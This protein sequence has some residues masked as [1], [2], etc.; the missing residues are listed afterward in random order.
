MFSSPA[1]STDGK[2]NN[3]KFDLHHF[4]CRIF[5]ENSFKLCI[6]FWIECIY[7]TV[8]YYVLSDNH[9]PHMI[10]G[11]IIS[12]MIQLLKWC[13]CTVQETRSKRRSKRPNEKIMP[14]SYRLWYL[15]WFLDDSTNLRPHVNCS[16]V[17]FKLKCWNDYYWRRT[18]EFS[19]WSR[20]YRKYHQE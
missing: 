20:K 3:R 15:P 17:F 4:K 9:M 12:I 1:Y 7:N 8:E 11:I 5:I 2:H 6:Y 10:C 18:G 19:S 16:F 14:K 13:Y